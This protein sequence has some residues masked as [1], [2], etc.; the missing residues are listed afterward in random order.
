VF[1]KIVLGLGL[2]SLGLF[3][4]DGHTDIVPRA[5][6][7]I[8]FAS[9]LYYLIGDKIKAFFQ[10]RKNS[11]ADDLNEVQEVLKSSKDKKEL[12]VTKL[13]EAEKIAEDIIL[14]ANRDS[15]IITEKMQQDVKVEIAN[16]EKQQLDVIDLEKKKVIKAVA[17]Q[18]LRDLFNDG[19]LSIS[20]QNIIDIIKKKVA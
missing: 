15:K 6:N 1:Y 17:D 4:S 10:D 9:I 5:I 14:V 18:V 16:L 3:A 2:L 7:F 11:I 12:A 13:R 19:A 8:I 20:N